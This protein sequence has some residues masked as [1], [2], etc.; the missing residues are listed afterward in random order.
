MPDLTIIIAISIITLGFLILAGLAIWLALDRQ[1]HNQQ[2]ST[3]QPERQN[4][5]YSASQPPLHK[6]RT[7]ARPAP[8]PA[9]MTD[10]EQAPA[11]KRAPAGTGASAT[12]PDPVISG[13]YPSA[14]LYDQTILPDP[15]KPRTRKTE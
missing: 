6:P 15:P 9:G 3:G 7:L 10:S 2:A 11:R 4:T 1:R 8:V 5:P 12:V 14:S 13:E